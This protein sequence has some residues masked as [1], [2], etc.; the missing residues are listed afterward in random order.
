[1]LAVMSDVFRI[2]CEKMETAYEIMESFQAM[3]GQPF[4]HQSCHDAFKATM[5]AKM[6]VETSVRE[7]VLKM[8]N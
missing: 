4:D 6:K 2:K 5:N 1:M 8:I 7:H 3:I